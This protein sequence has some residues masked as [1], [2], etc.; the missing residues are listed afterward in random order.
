MTPS[1]CSCNH[2]TVCSAFVESVCAAPFAALARSE[3][4][5]PACAEAPDFGAEA[6]PALFAAEP[7]FA[8]APLAAA[9]FAVAPFAAAPFAAA[10]FGVAPLAGLLS[11][12]PGAALLSCT[13]L[14]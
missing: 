1:M 5:L 8:V 2:D 7:L 4:L 14:P 6:P 11:E 13:V 9:P 3:A 12:E 10:L